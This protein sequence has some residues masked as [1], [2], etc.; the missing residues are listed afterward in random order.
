MEE[1]TT[2]IDQIDYACKLFIR[3]VIFALFGLVFS[4]A[5]NIEDPIICYK[6]IIG[7]A[8]IGSAISVFDIIK[9]L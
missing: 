3:I 8:L 1:Q 9:R 2:L 4:Y 5:L 7:F 6:I